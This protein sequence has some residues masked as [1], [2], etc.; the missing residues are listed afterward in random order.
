MNLKLNKYNF[1]INILINCQKTKY[2]IKIA[3]LLDQNY[4]LYLIYYCVIIVN[5][6][7]IVFYIFTIDFINLENFSVEY[8]V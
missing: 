7:N 2:I 6:S 8:L 5:N 1:L 4:K 3:K